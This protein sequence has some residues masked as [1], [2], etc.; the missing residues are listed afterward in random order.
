MGDDMKGERRGRGT[1]LVPVLRTSSRGPLYHALTGV[2]TNSRA[3][4]PG[5]SQ[6]DQF[7]RLRLRD[8]YKVQRWQAL[9]ESSRKREHS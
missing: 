3:F 2:A 4:G 1:P 5:V 6:G 7:P 9:L 8:P